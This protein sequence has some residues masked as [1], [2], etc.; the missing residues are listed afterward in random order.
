MTT[1]VEVFGKVAQASME[2]KDSAAMVDLCTDDVVF[3]FPFAPPGR[4]T[5]VEGK[6]ALTKYLRALSRQVRLEGVRNLEVHETVKPE[7]AI[8][9]MTMTGT[10]VATG[11]SMEQSYIS[12]L[13]SRD[14]LIA[15]Y[16]DY[17][18]PLRSPNWSEQ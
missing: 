13:T 10:V 4:P 3:E 18:N 11:E 17:W 9:E 14:G 15:H 5:R 7:V 1:A 2:S 6:E 8:I 12:V 16:R